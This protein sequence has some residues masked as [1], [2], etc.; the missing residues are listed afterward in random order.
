M[1]RRR[2]GPE[3]SRVRAHAKK[4]F[5]AI[6]QKTNQMMDARWPAGEEREKLKW[7]LMCSLGYMMGETMSNASKELREEADRQSPVKRQSTH[8]EW[9]RR[10]KT[11]K[12]CPWCYHAYCSCEDY[13]DS[14][15]DSDEEERERRGPIMCGYDITAA[16]HIY[17]CSCKNR[18]R[19]QTP[20]GMFPYGHGAHNA[21]VGR[22]GAESPTEM[23]SLS[24]MKVQRTDDPQN[25]VFNTKRPQPV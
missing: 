8:G 14:E 10:H 23:A 2:S 19:A 22:H 7:K 3:R 24:I 15:L 4:A 25:P 18:F 11:E 6:L 16:G 12:E 21:I 20:P 13:D 5:Y 17:C 9:Q 1:K